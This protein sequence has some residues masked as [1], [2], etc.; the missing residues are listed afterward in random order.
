MIFLLGESSGETGRK[1]IWCV[2]VSG[3]A[4]KDDGYIVG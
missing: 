4:V 3:T 1:P 2:G